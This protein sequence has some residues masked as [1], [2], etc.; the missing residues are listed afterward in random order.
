MK[1][2]A[3]IPLR[4]GSKGI[5]NK[6]KKK[7]L[8]RP[9]YQWT[10]G[11]AIESD[12]DYIYIFTDDEEILDFIKKEY[13]WTNKVVAVPR[14]KESASDTASTEFAIME[15]AEILNYDFDIISLIQATSPLL[16][17]KNINDGLL[18]ITNDTFDSVVSVVRTYRFIWSENGNSL[19]YDYTARPRRQDFKGLLVENGAF[20]AT[21]KDLLKRDKNR[22]SGNIG[23]L[24]MS[25]NSLI[26][27]DEPE[28]WK[29]VEVLLENKLREYKK[30]IKK[31]STL[32]LDV[33]GVFTNGNVLVSENGEFA[34]SFSLR[35]GMGFELARQNNLEIIVITSEDSQIVKARMEKLKITNY[36]LGVKDKYALLNKICSENKITRSEIGYIGDDINDMPNMLSVG[37]SF[38]PSD[39][40]ETI[41]TISDVNLKNIGGDRAIR[42][43]IEKVINYN[44]RF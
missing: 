41:K 18:K 4:K 6:N 37:W 34:K 19:N 27:I 7:L 10:L 39:A 28:D 9:L 17:S 43:F 3:I 5:P 29:I 16:T 20:Y 22:L 15:L 24:E 12:L 38:S 35:D 32:V 36:Y 44:N 8:G 25:E 14:S 33:D 1:K 31:I 2:I 21:K 11:E 40:I 26:E 23:I 42:E 13:T 30:N